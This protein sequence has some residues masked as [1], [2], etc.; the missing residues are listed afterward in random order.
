MKLSQQQFLVV[1][2]LIVG[3][4]L[5]GIGFGETLLD[6]MFSRHRSR[7]IAQVAIGVAGFVLIFA[8]WVLRRFFMIQ[9]DKA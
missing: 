8:S 7:E 1:V 5:A 6:E 3:C 9:A 2:C 4:T